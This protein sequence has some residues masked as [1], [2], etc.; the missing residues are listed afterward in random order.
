MS[1]R[2]WEGG[3]RDL[4]RGALYRGEY[5]GSEPELNSFYREGDSESK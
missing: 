5:R 3:N 1:R 4:K 2:G